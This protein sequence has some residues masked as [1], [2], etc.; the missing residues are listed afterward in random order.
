M[1]LKV[2]L[3]FYYEVIFRRMVKEF[4]KLVYFLLSWPVYGRI[5]VTSFVSPMAGIKDHRNIFL[6]N[7]TN[8]HR[9]AIVWGELITG[10]NNDIGPGSCVFGKVV[11]ENNIMIAPNVM[12]AGGNH[13]TEKNGVPMMYQQCSVQGVYIHS[14]VWI[15]ANVVV[16]D[17][18]TIGKGAVLAA[19]SVII[20]DVPD[21]ALVAGNPAK[22]KKYRE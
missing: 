3:S 8:I 12:I 15:G 16:V 11:M 6:G 2:C 10:E 7:R 18:V 19:G 4:Y 13:G 9:N 21:Y 22:I 20:S 17:G 5:S 1:N 14:D